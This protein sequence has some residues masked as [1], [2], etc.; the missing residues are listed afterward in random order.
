MTQ[1]GLSRE[2]LFALVWEKPTQEVAKELGVSDVAIGKLCVRLQVPKPPRGYW[3]RVQAD[4]TPR[5]PPLAAFREEVE[6]SRQ[7]AARA[8][9]AASLSNLQQQFYRVALSDL[10]GRGVDVKGAN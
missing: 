8:I 9:S 6:R 3:A 5:R 10:Q 4:Q 7:K 2:E 1:H